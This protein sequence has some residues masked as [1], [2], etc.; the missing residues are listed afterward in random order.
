MDWRGRK[1]YT[2]F[3]DNSSIEMRMGYLKT[4][5]GKIFLSNQMNLKNEEFIMY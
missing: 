1:Y 5:P 3:F 4:I 2:V